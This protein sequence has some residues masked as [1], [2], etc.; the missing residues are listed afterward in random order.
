MKSYI[1]KNTTTLALALCFIN[2]SHAAAVAVDLLHID[3]ITLTFSSPLTSGTIFSQTLTYDPADVWTMGE[4]HGIIAD[5]SAATTIGTVNYTVS[6]TGAYGAP[7]PS[8]TVDSAQGTIDLNLSDLY[9]SMSGA[10]T[11]GDKLW[12]AASSIIDYNSYDP[13]TSAFIYGWSDSSTVLYSFFSIPVNYSVLITGS[14][15]AV[16]LPPALLLFGSSMLGLLGI[17]RFGRRR[18]G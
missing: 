10:V 9:M 5:G 1:A 11:G 3:A 7:P 12:D 14:V 17:S 6:S 4:Y 8:G 18:R 13:L 15:S 2:P 16:P